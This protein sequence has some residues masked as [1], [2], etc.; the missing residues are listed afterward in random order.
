MKSKIL[1]T[2]LIISSLF[3]F[4]EWGQNKKMFLIQVEAEIFSKILKDPGSL[5][6]PFILLPL[7]GQIL[8]LLT[9]VQKNP[10][11]IMTYIG[12]GG[13]GSIMALLFLIGCLNINF[14]ILFSTIPFLVISFYTIRHHMKNRID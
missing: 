4:L 13:I 12:I 3:G 6:H 11:K 8:L 9:L 7:L 2:L 10:N 14:M 5:I 1:N